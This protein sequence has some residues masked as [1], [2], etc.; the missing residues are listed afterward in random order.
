MIAAL[1][2][3]TVKGSVLLVAALVATRLLRTQSASLR[4]AVWSAAILG[5]L[6]LPALTVLLPASVGWT[7]PTAGAFAPLAGLTAAPT[8]NVPPASD[9]AAPSV[10]PLSDLRDDELLTERAA[11]DA[12]ATEAPSA[13]IERACPAIGKNT[14]DS[15]IPPSSTAG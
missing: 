1:V 11:P 7:V 12:P 13:S 9:D 3:A 8:A 10:A 14:R 4:H 5:Q 6:A 15:S 2:V